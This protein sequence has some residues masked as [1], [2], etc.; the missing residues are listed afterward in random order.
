MASTSGLVGAGDCEGTSLNPADSVVVRI[1][2]EIALSR[3]L[4]AEI[5]SCFYHAYSFSVPT[6]R[7]NL[8]GVKA[9]FAAMGETDDQCSE[10]LESLPRQGEGA[11][12]DQRVQAVIVVSEPL[13]KRGLYPDVYRQTHTHD[14]RGVQA[15]CSVVGS[16]VG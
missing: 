6:R 9:G 14:R 12:C 13:E 8:T 11:Y 3:V 15:E 10:E 5:C 2:H 7:D 4:Y 16:G 1:D